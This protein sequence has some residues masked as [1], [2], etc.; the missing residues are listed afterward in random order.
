VIEGV[1]M[2]KTTRATRARVVVGPD[3]AVSVKVSPEVMFNFEQSAAVMKSVLGRLGCG[4]CTS[5][6]NIQMV[7]QEQE[8]QAE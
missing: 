8:F 3:G 4:G 5:G 2:A 7:L 1:I 6:F